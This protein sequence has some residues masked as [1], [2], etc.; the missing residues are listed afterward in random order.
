MGAV[1]E[2]TFEPGF[3][4]RHRVRAGDAERVEAALARLLRQ[5]VLQRDRVI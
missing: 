2:E 3:G 1:G 5:R 4:F